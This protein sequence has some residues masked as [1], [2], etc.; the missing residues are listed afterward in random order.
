M[1]RD[2]ILECGECYHEHQL[3]MKEDLKTITRCRKQQKASNIIEEKIE[4]ITSN[5]LLLDCLH[6]CADLTEPTLSIAHY[7]TEHSVLLSDVVY[8]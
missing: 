2:D 4:V 1:R 7:Y 3:N 6:R 5:D 8:H